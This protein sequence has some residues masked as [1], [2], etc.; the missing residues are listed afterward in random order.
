MKQLTVNEL[1]NQLHKCVEVMGCG[2]DIIAIYTDDEPNIRS[3][4]SVCAPTVYVKS[5]E[6]EE[7]QAV[8]LIKHLNLNH[9]G[10]LH[11][12]NN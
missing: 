5:E 3:Y 7:K 4:L 2:D 9:I 12:K 6:I 8:L 10:H 1:I 11:M